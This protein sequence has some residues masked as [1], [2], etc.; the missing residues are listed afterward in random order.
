MNNIDNIL[1]K[2]FFSK[3]FYNIFVENILTA[4]LIE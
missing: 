4:F 3:S 2:L 1:H